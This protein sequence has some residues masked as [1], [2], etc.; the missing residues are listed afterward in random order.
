MT[1]MTKSSMHLLEGLSLLVGVIAILTSAIFFLNEY[2]ILLIAY[3]ISTET[4]IMFFG[5][6]TLVSGIVLIASTVGMLSIK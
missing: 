6:M 3:E 1:I 4:L 5:A 2:G